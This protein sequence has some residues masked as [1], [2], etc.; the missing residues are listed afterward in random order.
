M[1]APLTCTDLLVVDKVV[2]TRSTDTCVSLGFTSA[3]FTSSVGWVEAGPATG[4]AAGIGAA[5]VG[6]G[7]VWKL[8][9]SGDV[10][11]RRG[12]LRP[13]TGRALTALVSA[14][15]FRSFTALAGLLSNASSALRCPAAPGSGGKLESPSSKL[16]DGGF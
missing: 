5:E 2:L 13:P 3:T 16:G 8:V 15:E 9:G 4:P 1:A 6:A 11:V 12:S 10:T 7:V 14:L